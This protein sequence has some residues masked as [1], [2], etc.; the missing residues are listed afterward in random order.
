MSEPD[1]A[2][3]GRARAQWDA[4]LRFADAQPGVTR[5]WK[6]YGAR[7]GWQLKLIAKRRA[8][9]YLIPRD[10]HFTAALALREPAL[11]AV[12]ASGVPAALLRAIAAAK[13][14]SEGRPARVD[15]RHARDRAIVERLLA[16]KLATL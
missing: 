10:G 15:V 12:R 2:G 4:L 6:D 13:P 7:H 3:L 11:A 16:A 9:A 8:L 5:A 14:S 1:L